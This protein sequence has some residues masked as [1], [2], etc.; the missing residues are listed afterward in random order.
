MATIT[1]CILGPVWVQ[2][3][4]HISD[5]LPI[6]FADCIVDAGQG[7][8]TFV[9]AG[10]IPYAT[11]SIRRCTVFGALSAHALSLAENSI[12]TDRV[13]VARRGSGCVRCCA[14]PESSRTPRRVACALGRVEE[15]SLR[16]QFEGLRHGDV[17]YAVLAETCPVAIAQGADDRSEMG[18]YHDLFRPQRDANLRAALAE[19]LPADVSVGI[20]YVS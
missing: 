15:S 13:A 8:E 14:L 11:L 3:D 18:A 6:S 16:P 7:G 12:F 5:P 10:P 4:E 17:N 19:Y 2:A 1:S 20:T 9:S